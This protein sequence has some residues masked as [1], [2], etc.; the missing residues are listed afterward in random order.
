MIY[1]SCFPMRRIESYGDRQVGLVL[2]LNSN[3][4][5]ARFTIKHYYYANQWHYKAELDFISTT[6]LNVGKIELVQNG[7][8][9]E[10]Q[11]INKLP[12]RAF[13]RSD[14]LSE[15]IEIEMTDELLKSLATG[16]I[17]GLNVTGQNKSDL[18][19][20]D[21]ESIHLVK[22]YIVEIEKKH[23]IELNWKLIK[24]RGYRS[25]LSN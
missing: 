9:M 3:R 12:I 14:S 21:K 4:L 2:S 20:L 7:K 6:V 19:N 10:I 8:T 24:E 25:S 1:L 11:I 13:T 23:Q 5:S 15:G 16:G 18:L 17:V 22:E